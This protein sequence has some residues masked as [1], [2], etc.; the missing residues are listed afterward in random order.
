LGYRRRKNTCH[1]LREVN[2][3]KAE[4]NYTIKE[5]N[6]CGISPKIFAKSGAAESCFDEVVGRE[7]DRTGRRVMS[8][9]DDR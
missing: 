3:Y 5:I 8:D 7:D 2:H 1:D 6:I 4:L 9:D